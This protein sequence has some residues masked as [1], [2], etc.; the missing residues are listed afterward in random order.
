MTTVKR[1][2]VAYSP[3]FVLAAAGAI[4]ALHLAFYR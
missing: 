4:G 2:V 1:I 3:F